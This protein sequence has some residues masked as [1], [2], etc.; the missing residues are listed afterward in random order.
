V[1][2]RPSQ[3]Q[4]ETRGER[5]EIEGALARHDAVLPGAG[6]H[7]SMLAQSKACAVRTLTGLPSG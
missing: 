6:L 5:D 7:V 4:D 1:P 2:L 3:Q